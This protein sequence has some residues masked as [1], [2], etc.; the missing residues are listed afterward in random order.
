MT[1]M[2]FLQ[3][4]YTHLQPLTAA[5]RDEII[6]D[7]EDHFQ[8]GLELGKSEEQICAELGNPYSCALQYLHSATSYAQAPGAQQTRQPVRTAAVVPQPARPENVYARRNKLLWSVF[9]FLM[10]LTAIWVYPLCVGLMLAPLILL[11]GG[12]V[13][14]VVLPSG[15]LIGFFISLGVMLF[16]A[17]LLGFLLTTWLL[18]LSYRR[19]GF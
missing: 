8:A 2:E 1:K 19:A 4:L 9:F 12:L 5:E 13:A 11:I 16:A 17:G 7:F 6:A 15:L 18:R 3:Q 10:V 14:T